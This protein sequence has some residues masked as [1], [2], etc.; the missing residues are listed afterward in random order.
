MSHTPFSLLYTKNNKTL[1]F[2]RFTC[3]VLFSNEM[4][5][6]SNCHKTHSLHS[7]IFSVF[8]T[9]SKKTVLEIKVFQDIIYSKNAIRQ[10][11]SN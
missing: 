11:Q 4:S 6:L 8:L 10:R 9:E 2:F 7:Y 1:L 5:H 3:C